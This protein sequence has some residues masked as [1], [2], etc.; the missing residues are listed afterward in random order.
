MATHDENRLTSEDVGRMSAKVREAVA[1]WRSP[2]ASGPAYALK[3]EDR[4]VLQRLA[5]HSIGCSI[6]D[7][8]DSEL[9]IIS[10]II[11]GY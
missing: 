2:Q 7:L 1:R 11:G 6:F 5:A 4:L 8:R 10:D 3:A 9:D